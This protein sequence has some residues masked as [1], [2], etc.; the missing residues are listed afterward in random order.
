M[1]LR[2]HPIDTLGDQVSRPAR[3]LLLGDDRRG[4]ANTIED[5]LGAFTRYSRH[6]V[7][8]FNPIDMSH[9]VALDLNEF[10]VVV[11]HYSLVL[12]EQRHFAQ[13]FRDKL[14]RFRGLKIQFMQDE[15]RWVDRATAASRDIG[16]DVL[17]TV[18]PEP[19]AGHLYDARLPGVRRIQ[20]LTGYVPENLERV[21][22][23]PLRERQIDVGYRGRDLPYWFGRLTQE[24]QWIAQGFLQRAPKYSLRT[25]IAWREQDRIYGDRWV[26]F[27]ASCRATLGAESGAS[28]ADFNGTVERA[29]KAFA[30]THPDASYQQVHEA[31]L[32]PFEGNVT[33][34]VI[35]PR[36]FEAATLGTAL[37]MFPGDYSGIVSAGEHYIPLEKDFSNMDEVVSKLKDED[38]MAALSE[39]AYAHLVRSGRWSYATFIKEF[40]ELV[41]ESA[42][43]ARGPA[44]TP[45]HRVA[46]ME[47]VL[48]VPPLHVRFARSILTAAAAVRGRGFTRQSSMESGSWLAKGALALQAALGEADLRAVFREGRI[49]GIPLD[50]LLEE[51]LEISLLRNAAN[52]TLPTTEKF[53]VAAEFDRV[54]GCLRFVSRPLEFGHIDASGAQ[55]SREALHS[56][57]VKVV[58]WDHTAVGRTIRLQRP[59]VD[60]AIGPNGLK[61]YAILVELGNRKPGLLDRALGHV[62]GAGKIPQSSLS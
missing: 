16:V 37:V 15:Y 36:V 24:K 14:K 3:V 51:I 5:H 21:P 57:S 60:V 42:R 34:N 31:V 2:Y 43:G 26:D 44:P 55:A 28:I 50:S 45:R 38:Y 39:R 10:D 12:S 54:T 19:A 22:R 9:S 13:D 11:I 27:I 17:F 30:R 8:I 32:A 61:T 53:T 40:D 25:D 4:N 62:V 48:R 29:V 1:T 18:A 33:V 35:S 56:G 20:T 7:R 52:G 47:R 46:R 23:Q 59:R 6:Q 41:A 58:E 49:A